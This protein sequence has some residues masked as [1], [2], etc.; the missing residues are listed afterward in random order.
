MEKFASTDRLMELLK[1]GKYKRL[2]MENEED[3]L[4][5][6]EDFKAILENFKKNTSRPD[7]YEYFARRP[8]KPK[9]AIK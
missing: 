1:S 5:S 7:N 8:I 4:N 3:F 9:K 6:E 2:V